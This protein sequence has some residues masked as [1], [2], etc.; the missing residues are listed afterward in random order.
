MK[1][2]MHRF[3]ALAALTLTSALAAATP[4][5]SAAQFGQKEV[6]QSK[7]IAIA[8]PYQGGRAH[9]LLVVEQV[10]DARPCW[11]ESGAAPTLVNPLLMQF[12]FTGICDRKT[13]ANGYSIRM[14]GEDLALRYSLRVLR[15][16]GDM[17]LVG[18]PRQRGAQEII[19]GRTAGETTDFAKITLDPG[20]RFTKRMLEDRTLG[21]VYL[22][23]DG[24]A[25]DG[26]GTTGGGTTTSRFR[27]TA[28]DIYLAEINQAVDA[29]FIAG[30]SEDNTFRP[31][32]SLT[33]EQLVSMVLGAIDSLPNVNLT[34]PAA[35]TSPYS[36]VAANRWSA[37]KIQF[38]KANNIVSGYED[39]KFRPEQPVT[40][41][42][43]MAVMRR[44]AEY[45]KTLQGQPTTLTGNR[46][47][48]NFTDISSHWSNALV[49]QMSTFC[50]V[51]SPL[52]ERG[53]NFAPD[54]QAQRNY[55]AAATVRMLNCVK[56]AAPA[57][58]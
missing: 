19:I 33:R 51:A 22:T 32:A 45:A 11:T 25:P 9:Q 57:A 6:D 40:R 49:S 38:A 44:A 7:F 13:D 4:T 55:A 47:A 26:G 50:G 53:S 52:N 43:L 20:W 35:T 41:A 34:V 12:D 37:A 36:D 28:S 58:Q 1:P 21:H 14:N 8:S 29:G 15:R 31:Q 48:Q 17:V 54:S 10:T 3:V 39:G 30:F 24:N 46:P 5:F 27:D 2:H 16:D 18:A 23:Y 42:E 56:P